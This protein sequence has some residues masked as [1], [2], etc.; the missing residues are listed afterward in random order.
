MIQH[1]HK[2]R[3]LVGVGYYFIGVNLDLGHCAMH[4]DIAQHIQ[5]L[6]SNVKIYFEGVSLDRGHCAICL[7]I[8]Q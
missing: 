1:L 5:T 4:L 8:A 7:D 2:F 3:R 6:R